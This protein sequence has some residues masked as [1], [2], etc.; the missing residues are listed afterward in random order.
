MKKGLVSA[1]NSPHGTAF[2]AR[3]RDRKFSMAGKTG[4]AQ[5]VSR[6]TSSEQGSV[7]SH[8]IFVGYAPISSP[9]YAAVVVADNAGWGSATAAPIGRD[10]LLFAQ[11]NVL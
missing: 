7:R 6:D 10:I 5:V 8:S 2:G 4:T 9:K 3:I 1:I 11:K